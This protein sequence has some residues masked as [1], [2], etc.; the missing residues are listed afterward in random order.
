MEYLKAGLA[1]FPEIVGPTCVEAAIA[2][3]NGVDMPAQLVTPHMVLTAD[4]MRDV[5]VQVE[6][7]WQLRTDSAR[8]D[9]AL[10]LPIQ[11]SGT[12]ALPCL[13]ESVSWCPSANTSGIKIL[14]PRCEPTP[15]AWESL[16]TSL[17]LLR[18]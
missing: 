3:F 17:T 16:S 4:N 6:T 14:R 11:R 13:P 10:T 7:G 15:T 18:T 1:M 12:Q 2:A 9:N 5:Y 8:T